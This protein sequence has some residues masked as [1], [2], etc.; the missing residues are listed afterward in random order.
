MEELVKY[1]RKIV[2]SGLAHSH[3]G[4]IS[5]RVGKKMVI[6]MTGAMLD[7]LEGSCVEV[8]LETTSSIDVIA[9]TE[10]GVHREI[11]KRTSALAVVHTHSPYAVALSLLVK[12]GFEPLDS[13]S[14]LMLHFIPVVEGGVGSRELA[15]ACAEALREHKAAI[16]RGHGPITRGQTLD[17]AFVYAC[18]VE[19]AAKVFLLVKTAQPPGKK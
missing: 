12:D 5:K 19:H 14:R 18:C 3:F 17:E 16:I 4:N 10:V 15:D 11:Y 9:S 7:E 6:S 8:P 13:E 2:E 1:G